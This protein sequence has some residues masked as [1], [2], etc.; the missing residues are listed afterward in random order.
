MLEELNDRKGS[1]YIEEMLDGKVV[2]RDRV[3][4]FFADLDRVLSAIG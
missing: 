2:V 1:R 3:E 4:D